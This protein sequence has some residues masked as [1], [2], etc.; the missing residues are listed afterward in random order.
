[1]CALL[2]KCDNTIRIWN[3]VGV[4]V[5]CT[6]TTVRALRKVRGFSFMFK[7][8]RSQILLVCNSISCLVEI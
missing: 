3:I 7:T 1:M 2:V 6:C 5:Q 8:A 4:T